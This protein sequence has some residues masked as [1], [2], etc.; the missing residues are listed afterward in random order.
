MEVATKPIK[1]RTLRTENSSTYRVAI[2]DAEAARCPQDM[3]WL[4]KTLKVT[5]TADCYSSFGTH[6]CV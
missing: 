1:F 2:T 6:Q 4:Q 3:L 5:H